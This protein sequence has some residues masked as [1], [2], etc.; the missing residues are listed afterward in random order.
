MDRGYQLVDPGLALP[1][2]NLTDDAQVRCLSYLIKQMDKIAMVPPG[3]LFEIIPV[4]Y[5]GG[6]YPCIGMYTEKTEAGDEN[7]T[8]L[9][10]NIENQISSY[11][12]QIGLERLLELSSGEAITWQEVLRSF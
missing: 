2:A 12:K 6:P 3:I 7:L 4:E 8:R 11:V 1:E 10:L 9:S 5:L